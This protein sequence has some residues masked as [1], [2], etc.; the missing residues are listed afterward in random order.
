MESF[1]LQNRTYWIDLFQQMALRAGGD[2]AAPKFRALS[3]G[4]P[5]PR[6]HQ[7]MP[8]LILI[9]IGG[10]STKVG[11]RT[12]KDSESWKILME[13][14]NDSFK[15]RELEGGTLKQFADAVAKKTD[16]ALKAGSLSSE[17]WGLG[18]VWSNAMENPVVPGV[19]IDGIV[20]GREHYSKGEWFCKDVKNGDSVGRTFVDAFRQVGIKVSLLLVGNDTPLTMK[21]VA[22]AASG[23]VA[24]TGLNATIVKN[25]KNGP[26]ICNA[27]MGTTFKVDSSL[28]GESDFISPGT[29]A[30]IIEHLV[31]G[32]NLPKLF[33]AHVMAESRRVEAL[34]A[35][36]EKL[37][38]QEAK[39][40]EMFSAPDLAMCLNAPQEFGKKFNLSENE[41]KESQKV[42][43]RLITRAARLS[44]LL[45]YAS[46]VEQFDQHS[47]VEVALDSSLSRGIPLFWSELKNA[48]NE[49]TPAGKTITLTLVDRCQVP[50][51]VLSVPMM[52]AANA[53]DSLAESLNAQK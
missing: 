53:L 19:G 12:V 22:S 40:F 44:A 4:I 26:I 30:S 51:G 17:S 48:L 15:G 43:A 13:E 8:A 6:A 50:G 7:K 42:V 45:A 39:A 36:A 11:T 18:I 9:D 16:E 41:V 2:S 33:V 24:S 29:K 23:M 5:V 20:S 28:V 14:P 35:L 46:V 52:G 27:E 47:S 21:A 49:I 10:S 37:R 31:S 3:S 34:G 25:G 1:W 38:G 32:Q